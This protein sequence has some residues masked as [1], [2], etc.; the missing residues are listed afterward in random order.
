MDS[1]RICF[2]EI[3]PCKGARQDPIRCHQ[4]YQ[5]LDTALQFTVVEPEPEATRH[6][7][8]ARIFIDD[9]EIDVSNSFVSALEQLQYLERPRHILL[10]DLCARLTDL[11]APAG[12]P[13]ISSLLP[14]SKF[15]GLWKPPPHPFLLAEKE[16]GSLVRHASS[17][18]SIVIT[19]HNLRHYSPYS[20]GSRITPLVSIECSGDASSTIDCKTVYACWPALPSFTMLSEPWEELEALTNHLGV[21]TV[22]LDGRDRRMPYLKCEALRKLRSESRSELILQYEIAHYPLEEIGNT[23]VDFST[24]SKELHP[25]GSFIEALGMRKT[26][27]A[28]YLDGSATQKKSGFV[29]TILHRSDPHEDALEIGRAHV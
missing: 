21:E 20:R 29:N 2:L 12:I 6:L 22:R 1:D 28:V 4:L 19:E 10:L 11:S 14:K 13:S 9:Q 23:R 7:K 27:D 26:P 25:T 16:E 17:P 3:L 24:L 8:E 5:S 18:L 15:V